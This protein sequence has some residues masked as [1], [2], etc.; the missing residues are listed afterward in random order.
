MFIKNKGG[1]RI[2]VSGNQE[3]IYGGALDGVVDSDLVTKSQLDTLQAE[4]D[5]IEAGDI[6]VSKVELDDGTVSAPSL[7][8]A[9]DTNTGFYRIGSDNIGITAGG[10]KIVDIATTGISVTGTLAAS[11]T[12]SLTGAVTF[13]AQNIYK[14]ATTITAHVGG[15][16]GSAQAIT[17]QFNE[18]TVCASAGDSVVLPTAALGIVLSI[19]NAGANY[20]DVFPATG[21]TI[22]AGSANA[23]ARL[24]PGC[25][26]E[27]KA[28]STTAWVTNNP[29]SFPIAQGTNI[30]TGV[31]VNAIK[32]IITTQSAS[33][34]AG[35]VNTFTVTNSFCQA[36]SHVAVYVINYAGT[37]LTNGNPVVVCDNRTDGTF[38]IVIANTQLVNALSGALV[39]GFE[40]KN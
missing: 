15:G 12:S 5:S 35:A 1:Q 2:A 3:W 4:V 31:T 7:S 25:T 14:G 40:I 11:S 23:A 32:G 22:D 21:G 16:Q 18:V 26:M 24:Q 10:T 19:K 36:D 37:F 33:A 30:S 6:T 28:N 13:G 38:D 20:C 29:A 27:F 8:Y 17:S 34:A 39:I 9:A